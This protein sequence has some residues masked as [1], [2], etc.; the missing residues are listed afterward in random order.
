VEREETYQPQ[1]D[2][3]A[4]D[5]PKEIHRLILLRGCCWSMCLAAP[6]R[7]TSRHNMH[8]PYLRRGCSAGTVSKVDS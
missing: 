1:H 3:H 2:E 5:S 8:Q 4:C 7:T 6:G